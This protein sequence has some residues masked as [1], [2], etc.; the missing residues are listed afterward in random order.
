MRC[1]YRILALSAL[2]GLAG[3]QSCDAQDRR[4]F[5]VG[6]GATL[7][8]TRDYFAARPAGFAGTLAFEFVNSAKNAVRVALSGSTFSDELL[9]IPGLDRISSGS[10]R[11][12]NFIPA[13]RLSWDPNLTGHS[14]LWTLSI[15]A[16]YRRYVS[17][18]ENGA[19]VGAGLGA[20]HLEVRNEAVGPPFVSG[21]LGYVV[22]VGESLRA[23]LESG[24]QWVAA[25]K[26]PRYFIPV[27]VSLGFGY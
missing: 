23:S 13:S 14:D 26:S 2:L 16:E 25:S 12:G 24:V 3:S 19:F 1:C 18:D 8:D 6:G 11:L 27:L 10:G 9:V 21:S 17:S 22:R 15:G 20:I 5:V 4:W 7:R